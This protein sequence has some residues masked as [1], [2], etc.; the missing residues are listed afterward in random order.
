[1]DQKYRGRADNLIGDFC[2]SGSKRKFTSNQTAKSRSIALSG[3]GV[4][5][6]FCCDG[7]SG[8]EFA[9]RYSAA[10]F[11]GAFVCAAPSAFPRPDS[12]HPVLS[13]RP[14]PGL[15]QRRDPSVA[16]TPMLTGQ[17]DNI[18]RQPIFVLSMQRHVAL[19]AA[20]LLLVRS[21][22]RYEIGLLDGRAM[23]AGNQ[24]PGDIVFPQEI[25]HGDRG[26]RTRNRP[27]G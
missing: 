17:R 16:I 25:A 27:A 14:A 11:Q 4:P 3:C 15:Q 18:S 19:R 2:T 8:G 21:E 12:L 9:I 1:V 24:S 13:N 10:T 6:C 26:I 7:M 5:H 22:L 20:P 23:A